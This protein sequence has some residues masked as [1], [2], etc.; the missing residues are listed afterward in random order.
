MK[1]AASLCAAVVLLAGCSSSSDDKPA[2][3]KAAPDKAVETSTS[4]DRDSLDKQAKEQEAA[5]RE[6]EKVVEAEAQKAA[7]VVIDIGLDNGRESTPQG[8]R[9]NVKVGQKITLRV[10][11]AH[12]EELHVHSDPEHTFAVKPGKDQLFSF[13]VKRPGQVAIEA[14][15]TGATLVQ[16]VVRP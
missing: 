1:I 16:L 9:V 13:T 2:A 15:H 10:T 8:K 12:E 6:L 3:D 5:S 14:H 11:S 4:L 7:G